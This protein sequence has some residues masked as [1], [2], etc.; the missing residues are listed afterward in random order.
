MTFIFSGC[1]RQTQNALRLE[2]TRG[3]GGGALRMVLKRSTVWGQIAMVIQDFV[4]GRSIRQVD[5][6][7]GRRLERDSDGS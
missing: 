1:R 4:M 3:D 5:G 2:E 6:L 7:G